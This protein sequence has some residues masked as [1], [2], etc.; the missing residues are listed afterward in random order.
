MVIQSVGVALDR[1]R[2]ILERFAQHLGRVMMVPSHVVR[3]GQ[4]A[5]GQRLRMAGA[6]IPVERRLPFHAFRFGELREEKEI[7]RSDQR[8][9]TLDNHMYL[10]LSWAD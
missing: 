1:G 4:R 5:V 6:V 2:L 10:H 9:P 8:A 7:G 3:L